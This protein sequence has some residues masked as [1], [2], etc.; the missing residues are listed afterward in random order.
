V[1]VTRERCYRTRDEEDKEPYLMSNDGG[2]DPWGLPTHLPKLRQV[3]DMLIARAHVHVEAKH[4]RGYQYQY[5]GHTVCFMNNTTKFYD[6]TLPLLPH[7]LDYG[8]ISYP[9][10]R[11]SRGNFSR[12]SWSSI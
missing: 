11:E 5:T 8:H 9:M 2:V 1:S 4:A 3:E 10:I 12:I 7:Q 6:S